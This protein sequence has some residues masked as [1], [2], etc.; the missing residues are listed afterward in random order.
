MCMG[1]GMTEVPGVSS[2][3][4]CLDHPSVDEC[5]C[6]EKQNWGVSIGCPAAY[7]CPEI[8]LECDRA[9]LCSTEEMHTACGAAIDCALGHLADGATGAIRWSVESNTMP[10]FSGRTGE[11]YL[12]GDGTAFSYGTREYDLSEEFFAVERRML[13]PPEYFQ[14]CAAENSP[15]DRFVCIMQALQGE[16]I[17]ECI[18][19]FSYEE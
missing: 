2:G 8:V 11:L 17:E 13:K 10:G 12:L 14:A 7:P 4:M 1:I 9:D 15:P 18:A 19:A 3:E 16:P 6:F 5:C